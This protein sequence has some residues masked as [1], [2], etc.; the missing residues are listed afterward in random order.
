MKHDVDSFQSVAR[1]PSGILLSVT[2]W[3]EFWRLLLPRRCRLLLLPKFSVFTV[4][5]VCQWPLPLSRRPQSVQL[6]ELEPRNIPLLWVV[7]WYPVRSIKTTTSTDFASVTLPLKSIDTTW[8]LRR[9]ETT[10]HSATQWSWRHWLTPSLTHAASPS[11]SA[12][13]KARQMKNF[14]SFL[15]FKFW[16]F[17]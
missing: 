1:V 11:E 17:F 12:K 6:S 5:L 4:T 13:F 9:P 14:L 2:E 10:A 8:E 7:L 15:V 3:V 16:L